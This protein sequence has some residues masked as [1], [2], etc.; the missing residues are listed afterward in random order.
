MA[1]IRGKRRRRAHRSDR[2]ALS[3]TK[4]L[5]RG[6]LRTSTSVSRE[7]RART[8]PGP[9]LRKPVKLGRR[10]KLPRHDEDGILGWLLTQMES[11]YTRLAAQGAPAPAGA[12]K[13]AASALTSTAGAILHTAQ[14]TVWRDALLEY[15]RRKAAALARPAAIRP[16]PAAPAI[17]GARNWVPLGP[18]VV[19]QGQ[20]VGDQPVAGRVA[21]LVVAPGGSIVYAA[22]ASGGVF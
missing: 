1:G 19:L 21:R 18:S 17:A 3:K 22:S 13:I 11:S 2:A 4:N 9:A 5:T 8:A 14:P 10:Y 12:P 20:T 16:A 7:N 15:K 6:S